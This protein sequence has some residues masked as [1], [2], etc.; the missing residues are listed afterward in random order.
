VR[1]RVPPALVLASVLAATWLIADPRTPDLAAQVY[2]VRLFEQL[3]WVVWDERWYAGHH[4]AGYSLLLGPLAS[5]LGLRLLA[6]VSLLASTALFAR[7]THLLYGPAGRWAVVAFALAAGGDIWIGR[8][9]FALGVPFAV[10]AVLAL[11]R[12]R[13]LVAALLA[14]L[15]AAASPVAGLLLALAGVTYWVYRL[16]PLKRSA[17]GSDTAVSEGPTKLAVPLALA[18]SPLVV[19][20]SLSLLFPEGGSEPYPTTSFAATIIVIL[21]FL[22]ALPRDERPFRTGAL[23]YALACI[24]SVAIPTPMGANVARY[25]V[26]LAG[27][28][29]LFAAARGRARSPA[30]LGAALCVWA[31]WVGWGPVREVLSVTGNESTQASYYAPVERYL[32]TQAH[33]PVRVEVPFTR[34]HWE[35]A[36]LAPS[37]SLARGWEKQLD[38]RYDGVLLNPGLT[39]ATY[40]RWLREHAVAYVALPDTPLDPSSAGEARLI[41]AGLPYLHEVL[42]SRHWRIYAVYDFT[43]LA[44]GPG[45]LTVLDHD[46][47]A[48]RATAPGT[49]LVRVR[50]SRYLTVTS[51]RGC[52]GEAPGG[53]TE[54]VS[55]APGTL[56][57]QARFSLSAAFGRQAACP[58]A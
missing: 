51:G 40:R 45:H 17:A 47:F 33:G 52:V 7:L 49:F 10:G 55:R 19:A 26:L 57:V 37:V 15:C 36:L 34:S 44:T 14:A 2:R 21:A 28:V 31:V 27:P 9:S 23:V 58:R 24:L 12:G 3:G 1:V 16:Q 5:L 53:W 8:L 25:A 13:P 46:S 4:M 56:R 6:V 42:A 41:R 11:V 54:V 30:L 32:A 38:E 18:L 48:L 50:F 20:A 43:P 35:A 22:V 39:S 29:L